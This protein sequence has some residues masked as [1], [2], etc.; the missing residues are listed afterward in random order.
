MAEPDN[1][2]PLFEY[3]RRLEVNLP[4]VRLAELPT[5]VRR[6]QKLESRTAAQNF[7]MKDDGESSPFYGGNKVRKLELLLAGAKAANAKT[8][9]TFGYAGSNHATAT[10]VHSSRLGIRSISCLL[11]QQNAAYL[12]RNLLV[13]LAVGA[14]LHEFSSRALLVAGALWTLLRTRSR[15]GRTPTVI[16]A[17]GSS[18]LGTIGFVNAAFELHEQIED[19]VLPAPQRIYVAAG[20][21]GT[22][23]GLAIGFAALRRNIPI[24][25][26]RVVDERFV[27]ASRAKSLWKKTAELL[28]KADRSFPDVGQMGERVVLR[29]EFFGGQYACKTPEATDAIRLATRN[30]SL[31][32]DRTYTAKTVACALA[33]AREGRFPKGPVLF[34]NTCN[35]ADLDD[36]AAGA[37]PAGLP[38]RLKRYFELDDTFNDD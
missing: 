11:P 26:V 22:A 19:G 5:P 23:V 21:L 31:H 17:G 20:S 18:A 12:R 9:L 6:L 37:E 3:Y 29:G 28:H 34:W 10:A 25:A 33:D 24:H 8:V 30:E 36:L 2:R 4:V 1:R 7:W 32:L 16:A 13:S 15:E 38:R 35:S 14:E 27:N